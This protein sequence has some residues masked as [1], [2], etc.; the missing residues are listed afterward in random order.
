MHKK[1]NRSLI[2]LISSRRAEQ[3]ENLVINRLNLTVITG[4]N[5]V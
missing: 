3:N 4:A 2:L 1:Y 5:I